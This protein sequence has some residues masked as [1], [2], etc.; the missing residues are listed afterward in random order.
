MEEGESAGGQSRLSADHEDHSRGHGPRGESAQDQN[1]KKT[2]SQGHSILKEM[3]TPLG[4]CDRLERKPQ[5]TLKAPGKTAR[6]QM[7]NNRTSTGFQRAS[8]WFEQNHED[9]LTLAGNPDLAKRS[10][11]Q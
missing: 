10:G 2:G 3:F 7:D 6:E 8:R 9:R 4:D 11:H 1:S 5:K